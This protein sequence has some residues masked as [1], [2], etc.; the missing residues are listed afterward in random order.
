MKTV[1]TKNTPELD[2]E[3]KVSDDVMKLFCDAKPKGAKISK[4]IIL[5]A[6]S[7]FLPSIEPVHMGVLDNMVHELN[8]GKEIKERRLVKG[9]PATPG[10]D[11]K[12]LL[13][14]KNFTG[15]GQVSVNN[16]GFADFSN[17]HL[18]DNVVPSTPVA[19]IYHPKKGVNGRDALGKKLEAAEGKAVAAK[20]G[21]GLEVAKAAS[22]ENYDIVLATKEGF[23]SEKNGNLEISNALKIEGDVDF[24]FGNL[25]FI[26]VIEVK[27]D[28][29][30]G[31][32]LKA[33]KGIVVNGSVKGGNLTTTEGDI[34]VKGLIHGGD[35]AKIISGRSLRAKGVEAVNAEIVGNIEI[36]KEA[37]DSVLRTQSAI[38][39]P[40]AHLIGGK[41]LVVKGLEV[42]ELGSAS[43]A[44]TQIQICSDVETSIEYGKLTIDIENHE[45][46]LN[47]LKLHLGPLVGTP[48]RIQL[49][50]SPHKEK[51]QALLDKLNLV[52]GSLQALLLKKK[53]LLSTGTTAE[54]PKINVVRLLH[55]GVKVLMSGKET[56]FHDEVAGPVG[57]ICKLDTQTV[58]KGEFQSL[59]EAAPTGSGDKK[60][61]EKV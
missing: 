35:G 11:G 57:L 2:L 44:E 24:K 27:G 60:K 6:M 19:R 30:P 42:G 23:L 43:G 40:K 12:L 56:L 22:N 61:G 32:N 10:Q 58:E 49:L 41:A 54:S 46:A 51:M 14:V 4:E 28:V 26:G 25:D 48:A 8:E 37:R 18:F 34:V 15:K 50:R 39:A 29:L 47:L 21:D 36:E 33:K 3:F 17:L 5:S 31:F 20:L 53:E 45:R 52:D 13:L 38:I 59:V 9:E 1:F 16:R 7:E 55:P